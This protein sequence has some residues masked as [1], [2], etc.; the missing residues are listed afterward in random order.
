MTDSADELHTIS[1][2]PA[3]T[4]S[5]SAQYGFRGKAEKIEV[6]GLV[7]RV[8][9]RSDSTI[10][11]AELQSG[12]TYEGQK[13]SEKSELARTRFLETNRWPVILVFIVLAGIILIGRW[14]RLGVM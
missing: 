2:I 3:D 11:Q 13:Q 8:Q 5:F 9:S 10:F 1:I 12:R 6:S 7:R 4:F 14:L